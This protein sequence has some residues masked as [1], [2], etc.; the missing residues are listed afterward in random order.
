MGTRA[1]FVGGLGGWTPPRK[2][3]TPPAAIKKTQGGRLSMYLC[4]S[5]V[6]DFNSQN[7]EP[8]NEIWQIQ[9]WWE[10]TCHLGSH[11]ATCHLAEVTFPPLPQPKLVLDLATP[12]GCKDIGEQ[13]WRR[14]HCCW[15]TSYWDNHASMI[16]GFAESFPAHVCSTLYVNNWIC[17]RDDDDIKKSIYNET[18]NQ[19]QIKQK[20]DKTEKNWLYKFMFDVGLL[21]FRAVE[22]ILVC[23]QFFIQFQ[24][25]FFQCLIQVVCASSESR[26][27]LGMFRLFG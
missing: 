15:L 26:L 3:L 13:H 14:L 18:D 5:T 22:S 23:R 2:F 17:T 4:I 11:S 19:T 25:F 9:P 20:H 16:A 21:V 27:E 7:F 1:V 24:L 12:E 6:V 8:P 10:L